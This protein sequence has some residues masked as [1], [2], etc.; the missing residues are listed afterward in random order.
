MLLTNQLISE[1]VINQAL[2]VIVTYFWGIPGITSNEKIFATRSLAFPGH[3]CI[4]KHL[5]A[6]IFSSDVIP[7]IPQ[8]F[9]T[10][11]LIAGTV[12]DQAVNN[13]KKYSVNNSLINFI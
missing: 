10:V 1:S 2:N 12:I 13:R 9:V 11:T 6:K 4:A 5:V 7:G 8:K 3:I